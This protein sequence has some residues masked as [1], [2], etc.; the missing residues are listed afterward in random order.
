MTDVFISYKREER[1]KIVLIA[2][3]LRSLGLD[4]WF[5]A[6]LTTGHHFDREIDDH[7]RRA[8]CVLVCWSEGALASEWVRAEAA[9]GRERNVLVPLL[10]EACSPPVPFN[11]IQT[12]N[13]IGWAGEADHEG[14]LRAIDQ[15]AGLVQRP[16]LAQEQRGR[17]QAERDLRRTQALLEAQRR[18]EEDAQRR[19][20]AA[21]GKRAE[22]EAQLANLGA[23][24]AD[25]SAGARSTQPVIM[26]PEGRIL[27]Y[28]LF[29]GLVFGAAA[30]TYVLCV[31]FL[32]NARETIPAITGAILGV[33]FGIWRRALSDMRSF[34]FT[35]RYVLVQYI[36][37]AV[38]VCATIVF[39][40]YAQDPYRANR[41]S[42]HEPY[43]VGLYSLP[44][45]FVCGFVLRQIVPVFGPHK[46]EPKTAA[47]TQA[48][49]IRLTLSVLFV[50]VTLTPILG[51][52][53]M[54]FSTFEPMRIFVALLSALA[55]AALAVWLRRARD[56]RELSFAPQSM[57][58][59]ALVVSAC[60]LGA[61]LLTAGFDYGRLTL[62]ASVAAFVLAVAVNMVLPNWGKLKDGSV[63]TGT[64]WR[65]WGAG[66]AIAA[67]LAGALALNI[68]L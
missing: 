30:L 56:A 37:A 32:A 36:L 51:I 43:N 8:R 62:F 17:G 46:F 40:S 11:T 39:L 10:V 2:D 33:L 7:V 6:R 14:W 54:L 52:G 35:A 55:G 67:L 26:R 60:V 24:T 25:R 18:E 28:V 27:S 61:V 19:A 68:S 59:R 4:V 42:D 15:I 65:V 20:A 63:R 9:I 21:A 48:R 13:L 16:E 12:E 64:E 49:W 58:F 53:Y 31:A 41:W 29:G 66:S 38:A 23:P 34:R 47:R 1:D 44:M 50:V 45:A 57:L 3:R 22:L 5:D